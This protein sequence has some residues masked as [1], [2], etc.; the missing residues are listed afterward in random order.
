MHKNTVLAWRDAGL[1]PIADLRKP[2]LFLG[3]ELADFLDAKRAKHKRPLRPGQ[4]YCVA[5]HDAKE[6]AFR[7][8]GISYL[9]AN[10]RQSP[11]PLSDLLL[12]HPSTRFTHEPGGR[13]RSIEGH[14]H[15]RPSEHKGMQL[16]PP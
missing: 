2:L 7:L 8:G 11:G 14:V 9:D 1:N 10:V 4:I 3:T 12:P 15:G 16:I 6:P 5:C 13:S